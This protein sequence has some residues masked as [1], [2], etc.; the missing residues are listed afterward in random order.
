M[1]KNLYFQ[2]KSFLALLQTFLALCDWL[3]IATYQTNPG[4][5]R[6]LFWVLNF[7]NLYFF[8]YWSQLLYFFG[9]SDKSCILKYFIFSTVFF[10]FQFYSPSASIIMGLHYY[11]IMLDFCEMNSVFEGIFWV[12]LFGKYFLRGF[13][14]VA[15]YFLGSF[16][17]TQL[18]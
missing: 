2:P 3:Q 9:L 5:S 11:H 4:I 16:R 17:N 6:V 8:G 13:L 14:L 12:L 7:E 1:T 15:K 18:R 10:G